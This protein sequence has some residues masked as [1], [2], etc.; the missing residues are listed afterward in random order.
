[1]QTT[2]PTSPPAPPYIHRAWKSPSKYELVEELLY[3][4]KTTWAPRP[5]P[6][7]NGTGWVGMEMK[8]H[9]NL[10]L[11]CSQNAF[12]ALC[13]FSLHPTNNNVLWCNQLAAK[14]ARPLWQ[15][16]YLTFHVQ[17]PHSH[18]TYP[19]SLMI[20]CPEQNG[21]E[22]ELG[23]KEGCDSQSPLLSKLAINK[24]S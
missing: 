11:L 14:H 5:L 17:P 3:S 12:A 23:P 4:D 22:E 9:R 21:E 6:P 7:K 18:V 15:T 20:L 8:T 13:H 24:L 16:Q 1:M 2:Q 10:L 19:P